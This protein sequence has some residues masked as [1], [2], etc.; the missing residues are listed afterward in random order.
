MRRAAA[1]GLIAGGVTALAGCSDEECYPIPPIAGNPSKP[2]AFGVTLYP[3]DDVDRAVSLIQGCGGTIARFGFS[4]GFEFPDALFEAATPQG[5]RVILITP[6]A[7]QPVDVVAY[8][9]NCA[10][11]QTRYAKYNPIW[12]IWNE[13]NLERYWGATPNVD[14]YTQLAIATAKALRGA[15]AVDVWSGGISG[16]DYAWIRRMIALGAYD[17]MN[18]CA[19]HTYEEVCTQ[20]TSYV[21]VL[22]VLPPGVKLYTTET[23]IPSTEDQVGFLR[24]MWSIHRGL[25]VSGMIWCELRDGTAGNHGFYTLPYGLVTVEYVPKAS[26]YAAQ[27]LTSATGTSS[28]RSG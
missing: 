24:Q 10:A 11:I 20:Y 14:D 22:G 19:V 25:G 8:A 18:A 5:I 21:D 28:K 12:E 15:G 7:Q 4:G 3:E 2:T 6:Y 17:V 13:P 16:I 27:A 23:C 26:Y 1:L 9:A